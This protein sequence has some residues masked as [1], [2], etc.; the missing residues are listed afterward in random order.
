MNLK[1][2]AQNVLKKR[3]AVEEEETQEEKNE[4]IPQPSTSTADEDTSVTLYF[5]ADKNDPI[6]YSNI[7]EEVKKQGNAL[8]K[9][10]QSG[11]F[12]WNHI[13][14]K[15]NDYGASPVDP[16]KSYILTSKLSGDG[17][18]IAPDQ[19]IINSDNKVL[20]NNNTEDYDSVLNKIVSKAFKD[21]KLSFDFNPVFKRST[22]PESGDLVRIFKGQR[23]PGEV[24]N[25]NVFEQEFGPSQYRMRLITSGIS[26]PGLSNTS[27]IL[28]GPMY[29]V[30]NA[31]ADNFMGENIAFT[32]D[33]TQMNKLKEAISKEVQEKPE[34]ELQQVQ[35]KEEEETVNTPVDEQH[36]TSK[37]DVT[38][39]YARDN[40]IMQD[41]VKRQHKRMKIRQ[42][43]Y[44]TSS[45]TSPTAPTSTINT[46]KNKNS[47]PVHDMNQ[48]DDNINNA[49][50][51]KQLGE[52]Q[53]KI[54]DQVNKLN[55]QMTATV[56]S[57]ASLVENVLSKYLEK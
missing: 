44:T 22:A 42:A 17:S 3:Y 49:N 10:I 38:N 29:N 56:A 31:Q 50:K 23:V 1:I 24:Y 39:R 7:Y 48:A 16:K 6:N 21:N 57:S 47:I 43:N 32:G 55:T 28:I 18:L 37:E 27:N 11:N 12:F 53:K 35:P 25:K 15:T 51:L 45:P 30:P 4:K 9:K 41:L 34:D 36:P 33:T 13:V 26:I 52:K 8:I 46:S 54:Q 5:T 19:K 14:I 20:D 40:S 2:S